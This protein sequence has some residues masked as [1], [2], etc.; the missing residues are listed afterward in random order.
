MEN[1]HFSS[2]IS[3]EK[4][5]IFPVRYV[6]LPEGNHVFHPSLMVKTPGLFRPQRP[7]APW[8]PGPPNWRRAHGGEL[9]KDG[10]LWLGLKLPKIINIAIIY[11]LTY[12]DL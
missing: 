4:W 1:H 3:H 11:I 5:W 9:D 8:R 12:I 6:K 10:A 7:A 2:E